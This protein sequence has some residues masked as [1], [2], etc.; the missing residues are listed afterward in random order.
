M[1]PS[2]WIYHLGLRTT[3]DR[4]G[5]LDPCSVARPRRDRVRRAPTTARR[6]A[7]AGAAFAL[8]LAWLVAAILHG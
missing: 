7:A 6:L 2:D 5:F 1:N 8:P 3:L 4:N